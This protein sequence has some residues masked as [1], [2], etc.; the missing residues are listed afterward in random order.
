[1]NKKLA[2]IF[3]HLS[4]LYIIFNHTLMGFF[5]GGDRVG[6]LFVLVLFFF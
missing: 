1:M 3:R 5:W 2:D 6:L 4:L